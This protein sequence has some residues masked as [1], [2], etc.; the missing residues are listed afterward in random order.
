MKTTATTAKDG[1]MR[2]ICMVRKKPEKA[3]DRRLT[4]QIHAHARNFRE[5]PLPGS[6]NGSD[7]TTG[8]IH[9]PLSNKK[10]PLTSV[11]GVHPIGFV[12]TD[13]SGSMSGSTSSKGSQ[14]R[15]CRTDAV[16]ATVLLTTAS[17]ATTVTGSMT[18]VAIC[19]SPKKQGKKISRS[20]HGSPCCGISLQSDRKIR[21]RTRGLREQTLFTQLA[22]QS[23]ES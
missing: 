17:S 7:A 12:A 20:P 15:D 4:N 3:D 11:S 22:G 16:I 6:A 13:Y 8:R 14:S 23:E 18:A 10:T 1:K 5:Y 19:G 21:K 9:R 2:D